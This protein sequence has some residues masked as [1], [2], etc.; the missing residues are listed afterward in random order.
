[1]TDW[2]VYVYSFLAGVLGVSGLPSFVLGIAGKKHQ[3][4]FGRPSSAVVNVVWGWLNF[5]VAGLLLYFGH[6]HQHLLRAFACV[7]I[8]A[9]VAGV[10]LAYTWSKHPEFNK[11]K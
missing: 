10:L 11:A 9:L 2:Q 4:P 5:V 3:T 1:M 8:G 6:V 7:A